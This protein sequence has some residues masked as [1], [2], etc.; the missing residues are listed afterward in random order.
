MSSGPLNKGVSVSF[1]QPSTAQSLHFH[2][3]TSEDSTTT[4][5]VLPVAFT[6]ENNP[7]MSGSVHFKLMLF[8]GQLYT[9]VE[10]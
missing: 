8:K 4:D 2:G 7:C 10:P 6:A 1:S 5:C 3:S 9:V